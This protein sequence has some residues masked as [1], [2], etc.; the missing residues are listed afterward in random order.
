MVVVIADASKGMICCG[1]SRV[2]CDENWDGYAL[3]NA[4]DTPAATVVQYRARSWLSSVSACAD[5]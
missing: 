3:R 5:T 2:A 4:G 1:G